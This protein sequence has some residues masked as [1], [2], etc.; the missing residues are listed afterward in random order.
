MKIQID[1]EAKTIQIEEPVKLADLMHVLG[2]LFPDGLWKEYTLKV[3][4]IVPWI[5]PIPYDPQPT[6]P[7]VT[8]WITYGSN[9][10]SFPNKIQ[11]RPEIGL[12]T[13]QT[14]FN[15]DYNERTD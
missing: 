3:G 9:S 2:N 10:L 4:P 13:I 5:N 14:C 12:M 15:I 6:N 11:E 8:P 7:L 1:T